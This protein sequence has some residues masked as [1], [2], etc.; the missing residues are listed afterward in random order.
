MKQKEIRTKCT[1]IKLKI[2][3]AAISNGKQKYRPSLS[4]G[5]RFSPQNSCREVGSF[6]FG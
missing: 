4:S 2:F 3:A 6:P 1:L 5:T